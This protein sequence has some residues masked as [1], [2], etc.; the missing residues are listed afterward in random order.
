[1]RKRSWLII[2][3]CMM[4][5][6]VAIPFQSLA[7]EQT[8]QNPYANEVAIS[9]DSAALI[10][11]QSGRI[12]YGKNM[13]KR[14]RIASLTKIVTAIVA[15]ESGKLNETVTVSKNAYRVEGSS[16]YLDLGEK[17]KLIDLVY[18]IM[19]RSG[20]DAATA[21][22]E[23]VG[24]GSVQKFVDMMN[25]KVKELGLTGTH[26]ANPHGLDA[27]D[28]YSTAYDMAKLTAYALWNPIFREVV[29]TKVK[30]I[31]WEGK[32]WDRTMR[33]KNKMLFRYEGADGVKTGYTEAAGRCLASSASRSGRQLAV[34]VLNDRDDWNDSSK[35]LDYG[36][37]KY[38]YF[39]PVDDSQSVTSIP[40][41]NGSVDNVDILVR[42]KLAYP[43]REEEKNNVRTELKLPK[44]LRAPLKEGEKVGEMIVY[45][46]DK[47]IGSLP[48]VSK[49]NVES[50]GLWA[51]ILKLLK[52]MFVKE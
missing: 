23:H 35:M 32:D 28:H 42:Q 27:K 5:L 50:V 14:M 37:T 48:L 33:N 51:E 21:I 18:A 8:D 11:V 24:G 20:N 34:I 47:K 41:K 16:I 12:L 10:D 52:S 44:Q 19:M 49:S 13:D 7:K 1:M 26:F 38:Q 36:F 25:A 22:A 3:I 45:M 30:K 4:L 46:N 43:L 29:S 15:I 6:W 31:P 39:S 2:G 40:V 9:A 17:Q